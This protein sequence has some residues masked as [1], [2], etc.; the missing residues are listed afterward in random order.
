MLFETH[1]TSPFYW[2]NYAPS[3]DGRRFL[4]LVPVEQETA[5]PMTVALNWMAG[6]K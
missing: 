6:K 2:T 5:L 3:A 4:I 1:V